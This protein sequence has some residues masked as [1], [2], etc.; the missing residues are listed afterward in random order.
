MKAVI[1]SEFGGPEV[2]KITEREVPLINQDEVL[3][4]VEAAGIN[5][6]DVLQRQGKYPAPAGAPSDIPGLEVAGV[7][8]EV[9][10]AVTR[11][12]KGDRV[13]ALLS[14]GGYA[15]YVAAPEV[16]CLPVPSNTSMIDAA[17]LP[18]TVFTVW[19]NVFERGD[20]KA[21]ETLLV[22]GGSSGIGITAI[23]L[24]KALGSKVVVTVGTNEKGEACLEF[25]ADKFINYKENDFG[26]VLE[27]M[28]MDVI[29][30]M[31]GGDYFPKNL[32]LLKA[33]GR[34]VYINH[35]KGK[36]VELDINFLMRNRLHIT[37]STLRAR[38]SD[39]KGR[40]R[41]AIEK[42]VW[43]LLES[44]KIKSMVSQSFKLSE[45]SKAHEIIDK[46]THIGK[47]VLEI[48]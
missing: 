24:A 44:G 1:I 5:R 29:L 26:E 8:T 22:H 2:L 4:K 33:D 39:F 21:G 36:N 16:Q 6:P 23:Q 37:G 28:S 30:D 12:S 27:K 38:D 40:L 13:C 15:E 41:D 34:L 7:V 10:K 35:M 32:N 45:V 46:H 42:N 25:G 17:S 3:I 19:H 18:E 47:L 9:G 20:L 14:G 48:L 43:P 31:V 11:F